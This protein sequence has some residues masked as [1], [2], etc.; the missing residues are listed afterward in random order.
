MSHCKLEDDLQLQAVLKDAVTDTVWSIVTSYCQ[1]LVDC[2]FKQ[3][4]KNQKKN[5]A[6]TKPNNFKP[7]K[8]YSTRKHPLYDNCKLQAPDGQLLSTCDRKKA[9]WY[10]EKEL[11]DIVTETPFTIRLRFEPAGRPASNRDY[12]LYDKK[13]ACVVCGSDGSIVRK[14]VVPHEYRRHFPLLL[15]DHVSH[16][17]VP[18]CVTCHQRAGYYDSILRSKIAEEYE[19]PLGSSQAVQLL[20]DGERRT[21]RSAG[22]ALENAR[23]KI[24]EPRRQEL[25]KVVLDFFNEEV[26]TEE[27]IKEASA[28]E[29]RY[30]NEAYVA[31]GLKVVNSIQKEKQL[32]GLFEFERRWREHFLDLMKPQ[33]LPHLWSVEH[34]HER[35]G[36]LV[37]RDSQNKA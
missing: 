23:N 22:R 11:A 17:I 6:H 19:A 35:V 21:V 2:K 15:K 12:Y 7:F 10:I 32:K 14:N 5:T 9:D 25:E 8:L 26:I 3:K 16:D 1:G 36:G 31:H 4:N 30:R 37:G 27:L 29:T 28:L 24:P 18:L 34:N 20:E 13:N 33:Y